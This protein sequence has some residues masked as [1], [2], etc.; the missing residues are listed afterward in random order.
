M[1]LKLGDAFPRDERFQAKALVLENGTKIYN[2]E[3]SQINAEAEIGADC[4]IHTFVFI[5]AKVKI[6]ARVKIQA[7]AFI[8]D[9][10]TIGDDCFIGPHVCFT[11]DKYA[12]SNGKGWAETHVEHG[13]RIY[14]G[15]RILAG[16]TVGKGSVVGMG[17]NVVK[18]VEPGI[19]VVGNP[20]RPIE[21][22]A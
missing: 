1:S 18:N 10:V 7:Y 19:T 17:S 11:N 21:K 2:P 6:G 13:A 14:A 9:G 16:V 20:A 15:S 22:K 8:P 3:K 4:V 12:P 5:G